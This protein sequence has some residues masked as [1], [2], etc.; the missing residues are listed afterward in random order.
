VRLQ[1][2]PQ[3]IHMI[4]VLPSWMFEDDYKALGKLGPR[5]VL[6]I[7][8]RGPFALLTIQIAKAG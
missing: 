3:R 5:L 1:E 7:H 8:K 6:L 4:K 2:I